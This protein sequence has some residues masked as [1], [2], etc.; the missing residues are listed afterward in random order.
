MDFFAR[1]D[2]ARKKTG[3]LIV[4]FS[5]AVACI[6]AGLYI[7]ILLL[8]GYAEAK[9]T[10]YGYS[11]E[12]AQ[13]DLWNSEVFFYATAFT[14][15]VVV[16]GS[17]YK[18][19][20]LRG[21]GSRVAESLGGRLVLPNTTDFE[22]RQLLNIV[23]EIALA[24]GIPP[25]PVYVMDDQEGINAF[26]AGYRPNDA[27]VSV[28][29]GL[30]DHLNRDETQGVIAHEFSHILNG[31]MRL[32]IRLIG[33]LHGI[34]L[35]GIIGEIVLRGS[36]RSRRGKGGGAI[37][38]VGLA[39]M[40]LGY[41]G[42]FFGKLIKAA[43][44]RQREYLADAS[45]VQFTRNPG[46]IA[47]ALKKIG[48]LVFG[49]QVRHP[50]A[51]EASHMFF[52]NGVRPSWLGLMATHPPLKDRILQID[53]DFDGNFPIVQERVARTRAETPPAGT[54][55]K[56]MPGPFPG[57]TFPFP[58]PDKLKAPILMT[59][60]ATPAAVIESIGVPMREH[61]DA[62]R[63]QLDALPE[64]IR[65]AA[66]EPFGARAVIYVL[67]LDGDETVRKLQL[68]HLEQSA[69]KAVL[70][71]TL[72]LA[73]YRDQCPKE[74]RLSL[75]DLCVPALRTM[76]ED[77]LVRFRAN[78]DVLI[79]ADEQID[80]FEYTLRHLLVRNL[81]KGRP[82]T[83]QIYSLRGVAYEVSCVLSLL[84]RQGHENDVEAAKA[85]AKAAGHL[86]QSKARFEFLPKEKAGL[87]EVDKALQHLAMLTPQLK[88]W[89][90]V[91]CLQSLVYDGKITVA[92][93]ELF[94]ALAAA[95]DVPVSPWLPNA[96]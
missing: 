58:F 72:K 79:E 95:L 66:R 92:E 93:G 31:D 53:P 18:V 87:S 46:G 80:L 7:V 23:E 28:T 41:A 57:Q 91:A 56:G 40:V 85:F 4:Y 77:Q 48:G 21:G 22:E 33:V 50:H 38:L 82:E 29:R 52:G 36:G 89:V 62:M 26:A 42:V 81:A 83:S 3:R 78:V 37:V 17:L 2:A 71:E 43:V 20:Q 39:M 49:S 67:L 5:L 73:Q 1:Q 10:S 55:S 88:K 30:L 15:L 44:S 14:L 59:M 76:S 25:P 16:S 19:S 94:R 6:I 8:F 63:E 32:N 11:Q 90:I 69:D 75:V 68:H 34:L 45:A 24:S 47:G 27:V 51:E 84:A 61:L 9:T 74:M 13:L 35:L 12:P 54:K 86:E 65:A 64:E 96:V 70:A 60:A